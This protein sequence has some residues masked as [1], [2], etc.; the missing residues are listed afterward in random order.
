MS[1]SMVLKKMEALKDV[2]TEA[3]GTRFDRMEWRKADI[4]FIYTI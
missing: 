1:M 4:R 3:Y 2:A